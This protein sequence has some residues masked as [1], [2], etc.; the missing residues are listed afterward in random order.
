V[1]L[2]DKGQLE[3]SGEMT[4]AE[5][6]GTDSGKEEF[7]IRRQDCLYAVRNHETVIRQTCMRSL[8]PTDGQ[9]HSL[10]APL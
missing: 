4:G 7:I 8:L 10:P 6:K 3:V 5:D 9:Y 1:I 2:R